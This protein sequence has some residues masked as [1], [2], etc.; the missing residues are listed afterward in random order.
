MSSLLS[1]VRITYQLL[2]KTKYMYRK[3]S[4]QKHFRFSPK[5]VCG[6]NHQFIQSLQAG[7]NRK[8]LVS[9]WE[10]LISDFLSMDLVVH[11][12]LLF[13]P[14]PQVDG[15]GVRRLAFQILLQHVLFDRQCVT[16]S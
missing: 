5:Y 10:E 4:Y 2:D 16:Q 11:K 6:L 7:F 14:N 12:W 15:E 3:Y 8:V 1:L 13:I 9:M